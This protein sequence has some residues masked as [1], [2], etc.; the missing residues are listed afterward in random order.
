MHERAG[1]QHEIDVAF[2]QARC[3]EVEDHG[4]KPMIGVHPIVDLP[5]RHVEVPQYDVWLAG[6]L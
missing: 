6:G 1:N 2:A 3:P 5:S 4:V